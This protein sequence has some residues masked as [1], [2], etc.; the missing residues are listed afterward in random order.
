MD[1][2]FQHRLIFTVMNDYTDD[3]RTSE[4][5]WLGIPTPALLDD[6]DYGQ[7]ETT[8]IG[9]EINDKVRCDL[10]DLIG[11]YCGTFNFFD[12]YKKEVVDRIRKKRK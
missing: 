10:E 6:V 11:K 2:Q 4:L 9:D 3:Q 8:A 12:Q 5:Y 7:D 1:V